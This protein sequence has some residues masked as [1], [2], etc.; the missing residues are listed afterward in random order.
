MSAFSPIPAFTAAALALH[1]AAGLAA[2]VPGD[3]NAAPPNAAGQAPA[4]P[5]QTRAPVLADDIPLAT[6]V[7]ADGL[8]HPWG[9][10]ALLATAA[11]SPVVWTGA[12]WLG[13]TI[14]LPT[15]MEE[16]RTRGP[17]ASRQNAGALATELTSAPVPAL[18]VAG[19]VLAAL[20]EESL[21]RGAIWSTV[22]GFVGRVVAAPADGDD[23]LSQAL[24]FA[25]DLSAAIGQG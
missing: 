2:G 3:F 8:D 15:L 23:A 21:F 22:Q 14:A 11:A 19:V 25:R 7:L 13:L 6:T 20:A 1:A 16:L 18:L 12:V 10:A 17:G 9:M 4:F 24:G 5:G